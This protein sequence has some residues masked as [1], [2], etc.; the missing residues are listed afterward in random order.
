MKG[1]PGLGSPESQQLSDSTNYRIIPAA[2]SPTLG[3]RNEKRGEP[4]ELYKTGRLTL[5]HEF[6]ESEVDMFGIHSQQL[7][8]MFAAK[9]FL[10]ATVRSPV[11]RV[12]TADIP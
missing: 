1:P 9:S 4:L 8:G 3:M 6:E 11:K 7:K 10:R 12:D 5:S 2:D